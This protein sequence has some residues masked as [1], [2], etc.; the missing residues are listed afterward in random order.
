MVA[1]GS[2]EE[3]KADPAAEPE[4]EPAAEPE[5]EP[6]AKP[7][8]EPAAEPEAELAGEPATDPGAEPD[9]E[10][11]GLTDEEQA[12]V[13]KA[14]CA[15]IGGVL[16]K[17]KNETSTFCSDFPETKEECIAKSGKQGEFC[18]EGSECISTGTEACYFTIPK[19]LIT[20]AVEKFFKEIVSSSAVDP[21][22]SVPAD[23]S[24]P[25][26]ETAPA[27]RQRRRRRMRRMRRMR[28]RM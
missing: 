9:G 7:E 1:E 20:P 22:H 11:P 15:M 4:A 10:P 21:D 16:L 24:T 5:A 17:D 6:A 8:D 14:F 12:E 2:P 27:R 13:D 3:P 19:E 25:P 23:E 18:M 28:R 26:A